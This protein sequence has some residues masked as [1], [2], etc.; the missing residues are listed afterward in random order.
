[1]G[2]VHQEARLRGALARGCQF[3]VPADGRADGCCHEPVRERVGRVE[4]EVDREEVDGLK[5]AI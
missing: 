4:D 5:V 2:S 3:A 1:M